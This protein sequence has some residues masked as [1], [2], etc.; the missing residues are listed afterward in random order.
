[1]DG[2][3]AHLQLCALDRL[4]FWGTAPQPAQRLSLLMSEAQAVNEQFQEHIANLVHRFN[5]AKH[6]VDLDLDC[7]LSCLPLRNDALLQSDDVAEARPG[8]LKQRSRAEDKVTTDYATHDIPEAHLLDLVRVQVKVHDPFAA[9]AFY[10]FV[11]QMKNCR[12]SIKTSL[13]TILFQKCTFRP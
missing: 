6:P 2:A 4:S 9:F 7:E 11:E 13:R 1:M 3:G 12:G 5:Q 10:K 8:P